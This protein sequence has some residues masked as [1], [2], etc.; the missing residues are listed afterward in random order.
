MPSS[1]L[2]TC[3]LVAA[4]TLASAL[5][6]SAQAAP[7][8]HAATPAA[9]AD[10]VVISVGSEQIRA[11]QF[12][13]LIANAPAQNRAAMEANKRAV[14]DELG[15]M[16]ALVQEARRR[17]LDQ[18][19]N[20]KAKM[21]LA[22]DDALAQSAVQ[23]IAATT[24]PTDADLKAYYDA[25][26][27]EF[28]QSKVRHILIG[29]NE[30]QGSPS[31]R[32]PADALAKAKDVDA[33]LKAGADFAATAKAE[34]DDPGSKD[35][36]GELGEITPGQTVPEFEKAMDALPVGQVSDPVHTQFGYHI[37]EVESRTTLPF[38]QAKAGIGQ[39]LT[40]K[41]VSDAIDKIAANAHV[42]INAGFFGPPKP[43]APG[44]PHR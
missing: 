19:P 26:A 15:K 25:H 33:K 14:A 38:E 34:S 41:A 24:K 22:Q 13:A 35:Q 6:L 39:Q 36:G 21:M 20:Y 8:P 44:T 37:I 43:P 42:N 23:A 31:T 16:L 5:A 18:D 27:A 29:D 10:P 12:N 11:S 2:R 40:S 7:K 3:G 1:A 28:K 4:F 9:G 30:S 32:T 17:G